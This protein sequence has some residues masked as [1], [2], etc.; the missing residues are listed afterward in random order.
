MAGLMARRLGRRVLHRLPPHVATCD[1]SASRS[2]TTRWSLTASTRSSATHPEAS[3][4]SATARRCCGD[5]A[6]TA[7]TSRRCRGTPSRRYPVRP[8][9]AFSNL[10]YAFVLAGVGDIDALRTYAETVVFPAYQACLALADFAPDSPAEAADRL[11]DHEDDFVAIGGS[12]AATRSTRR[13]TH[14]RPQP[15]RPHTTSTPPTRTTTHDTSIN[16]RQPLARKTPTP[17]TP[18]PRHPLRRTTVTMCR[19]DREGHPRFRSRVHWA[20][21][22]RPNT[23]PLVQRCAPLRGAHRGRG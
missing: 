20:H 14:R 2:V 17:N 1:S 5:S 3:A 23:L 18:T 15:Q 9:A 16:P 4:P 7:R 22:I 21:V 10:H 11:L 13:H 19:G 6:S 8:G 12:R